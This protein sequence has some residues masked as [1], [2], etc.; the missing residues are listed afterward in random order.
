METK[1]ESF[2][3]AAF[4]HY[5]LSC[6]CSQQKTD[7]HFHLPKE[8]FHCEY[9]LYEFPGFSI[10]VPSRR[11]VWIYLDNCKY[12]LYLG[13]FC[14]LKLYI[15]IYLRK[16]LSKKQK[17]SLWHIGNEFIRSLRSNLRFCSGCFTKREYVSRWKKYVILKVLMRKANIKANW[18]IR[19]FK[20]QYILW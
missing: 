18:C 7:K 16:C 2:T 4:M 13:K 10:Y 17:V 14:K 1:V 3:N 9:F 11:R 6:L 12:L 5:G 8:T 20:S 15:Y 19:F